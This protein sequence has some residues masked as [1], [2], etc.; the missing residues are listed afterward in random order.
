MAQ[1]NIDFGTFPDDPDADAI[2]TAFQKTQENFSEIYAG[3]VNQGVTSINRTPQPGITVNS[4]TGNVLI[5]ANLS[6]VTVES[7][8]LQL[9]LGVNPPTNTVVIT[10]G[11]QILKI[12]IPNIANIPNANVGGNLFVGGW[13]NFGNAVIINQGNVSVNGDISSNNLTVTGNAS[14]GNL[15]T[16]GVLSATGNANV[17]NLGTAGLIVAIGNISGGNINTTGLVNATGNVSGGNLSTSGTLNVTG[18]AN[19]GNIGGSQGIFTGN[20][21]AGNV[22]GGNLVVANFLTGTLTTASQPNITSVGTLT[23]LGVNGNITAANITANTGVFTGNGSGLSALAG[24]NVS[25]QVANAIVAGTVYTNAQPNITSVGTLTSL[26]ITGNLSAGNISTGGALNVTGNANVGNLGATGVVATTLGGTLTTNAQPNITSVG[27]L[28]S[29]GVT[30]NITAGNLYANSGT[31]GATL[32][33][34]TLTTNAQ[35]NISSV[36][37]LSSLTVSGNLSSGNANLGNLARANFIQGDGYLLTNLSVTS[38]TFIANGSSNIALGSSGGN[39]TVTIGGVSNVVVIS[40]SGANITGTLGVTGNANIGN[41]GAV[42]FVGN[43]Q[44]TVLTNSQP[45]ITS[46]GTLTGLTVNGVSNLGPNGNVIISG[47]AANAFLKTDGAGNLVWDTATLVP[48]QGS[49]TQIIFNDG[50]ATYA[51]N[52]GFTF[53]KTNGNVAIPGNLSLAGNLAANILT[54][55]TLI[56]NAA[57]VNAVNGLTFLIVNGNINAANLSGGNLVTANFFAGNA[58]N[59]FGIPGANITGQ[60]ANA[61]V[62]GTVYTAAQPNITSLGT[63]TGL[64]VNGNVTAANIIANTGIFSGNG[65]G[66]THL[67]A[68]DI[69]TGTLSQARLANS[70]VILGN[71]T[72]TLGTTVTS[73]AGLNAVSATTLSVSGNANAGNIGAAAGVFTSVSGNG[74]ALTALNASNI[75]SGTLAQ[76]RL[77]NS[78]LTLGNTTLTL[79]GTTTTVTGLSSVTSTTFVGALTGDATTAGTVTTAAQPNITSVGT[80]TSLA[81]SGNVTAAN[82]TANSYLIRSVASGISA[83][84][85]VQ[86]NATALTKEFNQVTT[87][88][89]GAGVRLPTAVAGMAITITNTSANSLLVYPATSATINSLAL[90]AG[91]TQASGATL[92]FVAMTGSQWYTVGATY[93]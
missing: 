43:L 77:A 65:S 42:N 5:T 75:A 66:L 22:I 17:G 86:A 39:A 13:A 78:T 61:L 81:V 8:S 47:G 24:S 52:T 6:C 44:G 57:N 74:I 55:N 92:Q 35:P 76:S 56:A 53:N 30:G 36:G 63:L 7:T 29:L 20:I 16:T 46:L 12:N 38:G 2:R 40:T 93:A 50:G 3:L 33:T 73:V 84:G 89:S 15:T 64:S 27:S 51:G 19:V 85:T 67:N 9:N 23:G 82:V 10:S 70:N 48:A 4:P 54:S 11:S 28:S 83:A 26:A 34:G 68:T 41:V 21:S 69:T 80:L 88:A 62:A 79:G 14:A 32:L 18:N 59:L 58:S 87:V 72:L 37:T 31:L 91:F 71:T 49:N 1:K 25:G 45:N 90:N 60:V